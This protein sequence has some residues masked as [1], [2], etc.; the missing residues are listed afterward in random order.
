[1]KHDT[2]LMLTAVGFMG[3]LGAFVFWGVKRAHAA[4]AQPQ[5]QAPPAVAP[6]PFAVPQAP[7]QE[8]HVSPDM[9]TDP[10]SPYGIPPEQWSQEQA[11]VVT[12]DKGNE[13]R[14]AVGKVFGF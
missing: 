3:A 4:P 13:A 8:V 9:S 7:K 11:A 10:A 1:M 5:P 2:K 12:T 14:D 6:V